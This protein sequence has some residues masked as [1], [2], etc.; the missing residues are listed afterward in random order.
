MLYGR[1][2]DAPE[3]IIVWPHTGMLIT[4]FHRSLLRMVPT[5]TMHEFF[6][7]DRRVLLM[8]SHSFFAAGFCG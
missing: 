4:P 3:R 7:T 8:G 2:P 5:E 6:A 1:A